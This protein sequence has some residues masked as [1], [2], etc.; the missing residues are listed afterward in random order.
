MTNVVNQRFPHND[1]YV[2][3]EIADTMPHMVWLTDLA[4]VGLYHNSCLLEYAG[5]TPSAA[6]SSGW[7]MMVHPDELL[8]V[9]ISWHQSLKTGGPFEAECRLRDHL[10]EYRWL[11]VRG[12]VQKDAAGRAVR[13]VVTGTDITDRIATE[14]R[15]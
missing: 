4:G 7:L 10:G 9:Q 8:V 13:W 15:V 11:L 2:F 5:L 12:R 14:G 1:C 3:E 6:L